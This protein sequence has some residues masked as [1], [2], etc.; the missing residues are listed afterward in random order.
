MRLVNS[1]ARYIFVAF[2]ISAS[3]SAQ[4]A[5]GFVQIIGFGDSITAGRP[6]SDLVGGGRLNYGGYEPFLV[7]MLSEDGLEAYVYNWGYGGETT[8]VGVNRI[9]SVL[10][11]QASDYVL[12][13]EGTNDQWYGISEET[14]A[15]NLGV[16]IDKCRAAGTMPILGNLTPADRDIANEIPN[17][18]NPAISRMVAD[19]EKEEEIEVELVDHYSAVVDRWEELDADPVHPNIDGYQVIAQTWFNSLKPII[20]LPLNRSAVRSAVILLLLD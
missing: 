15:F 11:T 18:Y 4:N 6:Y 7:Q 2:T 5:N 13:M 9:G 14:T 10:S 1:V 8:P 12:I 19:K 20:R 16:M 17:K 3:I